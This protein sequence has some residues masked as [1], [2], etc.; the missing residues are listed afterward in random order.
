LKPSGSTAAYNRGDWEAAF[1]TMDPDVV[2]DLTRA[3]PDGATYRGYEG[4]K[5]FWRMLRKAFGELQ[6]DP[7]EIIDGGIACSRAYASAVQARQ[8][9][10]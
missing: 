6:I 8:A 4:V 2:F 1:A 3:G 10:P 5:A 7:G 9:G